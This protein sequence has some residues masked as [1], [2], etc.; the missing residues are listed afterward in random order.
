MNHLTEEQF[1]DIIQ[2]SLMEPK[3]IAECQQ[4]RKI[5]ADKRAIANRLRSAFASVAPNK[6]LSN[7]IRSQLFNKK[8]IRQVQHVR[9][10][11]NIGFK[12]LVWPAAAAAALFIVAILGIYFTNPPS[13]MAARAELVKIH[14]HNLSGNHKFYSE[15]DPEKLAEYFIE[16]LGFIPSMPSLGQGMEIRGCCIRHFQGQI[17]G[18]YVVDTPEG[19]MSVI[20][21][22]DEPQTLGIS[23]KFE[24]QG[25]SF[26]KS[27]FA[28]CEMVATRLGIYSYC[29]VG[30]ISHEFL[31][32]L[33]VRLIP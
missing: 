2:G 15:S 29:A 33:L 18:S 6:N 28:K 8:T 31:A 7:N 22:T 14:E 21:V 5:L 24:Y 16:K 19:V 10:P 3:H 27:S 9:Q 13:A 30:E 4:C 17:V 26:Y 20:V 25:H 11:W 32:E 12:K 23:S 1:E